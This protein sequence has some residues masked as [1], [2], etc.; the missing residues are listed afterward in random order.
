[1]YENDGDFAPF[2]TF[3]I[4]LS[5]KGDAADVVS[6]PNEYMFAGAPMPGLDG[7]R[8]VLDGERY[9]EMIEPLDP[10]G[11]ELFQRQKLTG[12]FKRG[13][14]ASVETVTEITDKDG[15]IFYKIISG[16]FMVGAKGF[17]DAGTSTAE[18][19]AVPKRAADKEVEMKTGAFQTHTYRSASWQEESGGGYEAFWVEQAG[20]HG[21]DYHHHDFGSVQS[22]FVL[23][24]IPLLLPPGP[25][26]PSSFLPSFLPS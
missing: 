14:G 9:I 15:K 8:V 22:F 13:S 25:R 6:F 21:C 11:G 5:F 19:I 17:K 20:E 7:V 12:V 18:V 24:L 4:T 3:P 23:F 16:A 2:P 10:N 1:V 26:C